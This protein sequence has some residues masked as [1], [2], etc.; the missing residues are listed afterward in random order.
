MSALMSNTLWKEERYFKNAIITTSNL[1]PTSLPLRR[2]KRAQLDDFVL[3][4]LSLFSWPPWMSK[5][6]DGSRLF[7]VE[8]GRKRRMRRD[9]KDRSQVQ[10]PSLE[11]TGRLTDF[12][13]EFR[14]NENT[15]PSRNKEGLSEVSFSQIIPTLLHG[16]CRTSYSGEK[17]PQPPKVR[18]E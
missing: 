4:W 12:P 15:L 17:D 8:K 9:S 7:L 5:D 14:Y 10:I 2:E 13:S 11:L 18:D 1:D 6:E 16:H 3:T